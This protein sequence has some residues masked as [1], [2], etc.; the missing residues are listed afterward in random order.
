MDEFDRIVTDPG[1]RRV[2]VEEH[3]LGPNADGLL[4]GRFHVF[5]TSGTTGV[6]GLFVFDE[7]EW[8]TW[9]AAGMRQLTWTG[10]TP[11]TRLA[12]IGAPSPLHCTRRLFAAFRS[13]RS[14]SPELTVLT[15][16]EQTV[17]ALNE[18]QPEVLGGYASIM[19]LLADEQ[20][21]GRLRISPRIVPVSSEVLTE[22]MDERIR[23]AWKTA[24]SNIY[25]S[26]EALFIAGPAA[27]ETGMHVSEDL[28]IVES[29]DERNR[30]V[31]AGTPGYKLLLTSFVGRTQPLIRYELSDSVTF[32]EEIGGS[33]LPYARIERVDGR[34]D[35]ILRLP[36]GG[37]GEVAVHPYALRAPFSTL[38]GVRQY[39][40]VERPGRLA[41][42]VALSPEAPSGT[43]ELVRARVGGV[44]ATA[45]AAVELDVDSVAAIER[46]PG[47]GAKVKLVKRL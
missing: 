29:V 45:G 27:G 14:G 11:E 47:I 33:R 10:V 8:R 37:G 43:P 44:L 22:D 32:A 35:D 18:Y 28:L 31:A 30:P 13:G 3:A 20:L 40:I 15:P 5:S 26:T 34:N 12:A 4:H 24:P 38:P 19:A 41:V 39:Q 21:A 6:R 25:A 17:A 2:D 7:Q 9:I 23:R 1:L 42:R 16:I 46:E 36:A